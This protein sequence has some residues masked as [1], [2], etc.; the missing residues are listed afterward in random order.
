MG[1]F[2]AAYRLRDS[3]E[4][5]EHEEPVLQEALSWL[6]MHLKSPACLDERGNARAICWFRPDAKRPID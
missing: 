6:C 1:V 3:G 2:R 5:A 4:L